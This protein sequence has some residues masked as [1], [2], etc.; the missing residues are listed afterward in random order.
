MQRK[1][2]VE[3]HTQKNGQKIR[4]NIHRRTRTSTTDLTLKS[5]HLISLPIWFWGYKE[6]EEFGLVP[7]SCLMKLEK[8]RSRKKIIVDGRR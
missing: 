2:L 7:R 6:R 8:R 5:Q 3:E 4:Q 1:L